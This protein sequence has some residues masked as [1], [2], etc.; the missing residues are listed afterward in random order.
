MI[1][2]ITVTAVKILKSHVKF[3]AFKKHKYLP[4]YS[5]NL[6]PGPYDVCQIQST[7]LYFISKTRNNTFQIKNLMLL[8]IF[9]DKP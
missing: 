4:L 3:P 5:Q 6:K 2:Y 8:S 9:Q 1:I 7:P